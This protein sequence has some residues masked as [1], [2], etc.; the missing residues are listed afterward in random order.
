MAITTVKVVLLVL[1]S[2]LAAAPENGALTAVEEASTDLVSV[3]VGVTVLKMGATGPLAILRVSEGAD[4][5]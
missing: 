3:K 5:V 4:V 1:V 2:S